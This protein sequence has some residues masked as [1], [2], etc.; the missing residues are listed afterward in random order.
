MTIA[1]GMVLAIVT[2]TVIVYPFF[3]KKRYRLVSDSFIRKEKLRAERLQIYRKINDVRSDFISGDLT[4]KDY[5]SQRNQ[6][7]LA[8]AQIL[9]QE[10]S[11]TLTDSQIKD[12]LEK[13]I[14]MLRQRT[15]QPPE[16]G[17]LS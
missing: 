3:G 6:L 13:E 16:G 1:L 11:F 5:L 8:A 7:R 12:E 10:T 4:E 9:E 14:S 2:I 17:D 15:N